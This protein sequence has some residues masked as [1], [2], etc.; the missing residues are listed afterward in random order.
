MWADFV[1]TPEIFFTP[2]H[3]YHD[4]FLHFPGKLKKKKTQQSMHWFKHE[5]TDLNQMLHIC[6]L[7]LDAKK[8]NYSTGETVFTFP[9]WIFSTADK[10][11]EG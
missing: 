9:I 5:I 3:F 1:K 7:P 10:A 6:S 11:F 8:L 4:L 2:L